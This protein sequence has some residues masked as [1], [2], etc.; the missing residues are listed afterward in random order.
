MPLKQIVN[1]HIYVNYKNIKGKDIVYPGLD[2]KKYYRKK[3]IPFTNE[4]VIGAI[5][6]TE[7]WKGTNDV[8][9][10]YNILKKVS[11]KY[12]FKLKLAY[13]NEL[14]EKIDGL[15][16]IIPK[17]DSELADYY[18]SVDIMVAP[19]HIQLG[20]VHYPVIESMACGTPIITT[21]YYPAD[22]KRNAWIVSVK[23]PE[24][25]AECIMYMIENQE[26]VHQKVE[27]AIQDVQQFDWNTI[28]EK[29]I[30]IIEES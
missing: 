21:G 10:A 11:R 16:Y 3:Y 22:D 9:E 15:E 25:I 28:V 2:L 18:R 30:K 24:K 1:S 14:N 13:S 29:F 8:I 27:Q 26:L 17:N 6:R 7:I 5:N 23:S 4:I 12:N 19:G 20:A